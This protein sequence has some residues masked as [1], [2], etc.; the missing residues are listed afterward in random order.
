MSRRGRLAAIVAVTLAVLGAGVAY[1]FMRP[2]TWESSGSLYLSPRSED[3]FTSSALLDAFQRSGTI[4]TYVE[5]LSSATLQARADAADVEV[6]ARAIPESRVIALTARGEQ[7]RVQGALASLMETAAAPAERLGDGWTLR[8]AEPA[9]APAQIGPSTPVVIA[10]AVFLAALAGLVAAAT[11]ARLAP[12]P[13]DGGPP[14]G[15]AAATRELVPNG[16]ARAGR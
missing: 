2:V 15:A 10:A 4:G 11:L 13:R 9:T 3:A 14:A 7:E 16:F 5:L 8:V 12:P 1:A 6:R